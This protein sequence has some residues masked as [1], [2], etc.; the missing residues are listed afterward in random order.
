MYIILDMKLIL[1]ER[2][3]TLYE[4][5]ILLLSTHK[6]KNLSIEKKVLPLGDAIIQD[7][8]DKDI[9]LIER[10]SI[11]DLLASIK[12]GRYVEQSHR[13]QH[14][15][16]VP[17][18]NIIYI[19]EGS[20]GTLP[21][22]HNYGDPKQTVFSAIVSL[23]LFKGF[24]VLRTTSIQDTADL[25][26]AMMDKIDRNMEKKQSLFHKMS[27]GSLESTAE[28]QGDPGKYCS[29]VKKVKKDNITPENMGEIILCQIPGISSTSAIAIMKEFNGF[30][31]L[32][33]SIKERPDCLNEIK[34]DAN[35]KP[36]K[37][38]KTCIENIKRFLSI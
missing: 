10:K 30:L 25:L 13:L 32:V 37:I 19:I 22:H 20:F 6:N 8:D 28:V 31:H 12:D 34:Y 15:S 35:G 3:S 14:S 24:S 2:E 11:Q 16:G 17:A 7:A 38:S 21:I 18:H 29:V 9:V 26:I 33:E 36:R 5:C 1:D 4:R 23:N 27:A